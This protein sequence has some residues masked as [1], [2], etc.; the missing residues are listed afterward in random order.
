MNFV[1]IEQIFPDISLNLN[2]LSRGTGRY[3]LA[4]YQHE[5]VLSLTEG[6][7]KLGNHDNPSNKF[8]SFFNKVRE[9][10]ADLAMTPEYSCPWEVIRRLLDD[11]QQWP[12]DGKLWAIGAESIT[13]KEIID[14][15]AQYNTN[16]IKVHFDESRLGENGV[17]FDPL[18]YLFRALVNNVP[19]LIVIIQFKT[20]HMGVR[21]G[22]DIERDRLKAGR[23]VYIIRNNA[24]SV[25]LLTMICSEAM[26]FP[27]A[28][29]MAQR[30]ALVWNDRPFLILN[31][32]VNPDPVHERF[33]AFRNFVFEQEKKEIIGLNW[34]LNS[35]IGH[36][37]LLRASGSRSGIYMTSPDIIFGDKS[38]MRNNHK[39]GMY[40]FYFGRTKHAFV[41]NSKPHVYIIDQLSV[42]ITEGVP[43]QRMRNGPE[44][45]ESYSFQPNGELIKNNIVSDDHLDC[46]DGL[47]CT[48]PFLTN[49]TSCVL[50]KERL[51]CLSSYM[52]LPKTYEDWA[53]LDKLFSVRLLEA[54]EINNRISYTEDISAESQKQ[55]QLYITAINELDSIILP[56]K[57]NYPESIAD[58]KAYPVTLGYSQDIYA[59]NS[60][61][62]EREKYRYNLVN[63]TGGMVKATICY[64][65]VASLRQATEAFENIQSMFETDSM[66]RQR[67]VIF[68]K[69]GVRLA[70][71]SDELAGRI[72]IADEKGPTSY[73][74]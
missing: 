14:F 13:P 11:P 28:M 56:D 27:Q 62:I 38:R 54:T 26:N 16:P 31:P 65:G 39:L 25:N 37:N 6:N 52:F 9:S 12:N 7:T 40:Y 36:Q 72:V 60:K 69:E 18:V 23:D 47:H 74:G 34:N 48:N 3:R 8:Y 21:S 55:R 19:N 10:N 5:G 44:L 46:L 30:E 61:H 70:V 49:A 50:E 2:A 32:Q 15:T 63:Q 57:R 51:V 41:L 73:L 33:I 24:D 66:N 1:F 29:D 67:V 59:N 58:L 71:K 17:F 68:Y 45:I 4:L 20:Q 53:D 22:G 35:K 43:Q 64:L 42:H